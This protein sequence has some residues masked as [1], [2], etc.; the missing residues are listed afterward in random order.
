MNC[1][2]I[3]KFEVNIGVG[4]AITCFEIKVRVDTA[5]FPHENSQC[6]K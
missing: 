2:T 4:D 5:K 1:V 3:V 6:A